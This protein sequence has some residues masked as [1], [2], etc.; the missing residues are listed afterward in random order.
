MDKADA[1]FVDRPISPENRDGSVVAL[2]ADIYFYNGSGCRQ[3]GGVPV[4]GR[5]GPISETCN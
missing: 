5:M 3:R 2:M 4:A 1:C